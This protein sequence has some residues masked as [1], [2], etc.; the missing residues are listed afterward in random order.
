MIRVA[1]VVAVLVAVLVFAK[2]SPVVFAQQYG[3]YGPSPIQ[4]IVVDKLVNKPGSGDF[5]DNLSPS[6]PRFAPGQDVFFR[7]RVKNPNDQA[8][9]GVT[10]KDFIP[11]FVDVIETPGSGNSSN[12]TITINAGDFGAQEEKVYVVKARVVGSDK[13]SND[14]G[15][16]CL[17]N[18]ANGS[19]SSVSDEDTAQ[20]CVEKT[21][22]QVVNVTQIPSTGPEM[23]FALLTL[24]TLGFGAG[25]Y[26]RKRR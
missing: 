9:T 21:V 4:N 12:R 8:L 6:D 10:V 25:L 3:P 19:N 17:V 14:K 18:R 5:V 11:D 1:R 2:S 22:K 26:L 23:G 20:F 24:N 7:I 16:F 15:I 13:I